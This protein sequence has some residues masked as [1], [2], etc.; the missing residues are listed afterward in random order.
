MRALAKGAAGCPG[1]EAGP[2]VPGWPKYR[3]AGRTGAS[4]KDPH[5]AAAQAKLWWRRHSAC[6]WLPPEASI[7]LPAGGFYR[8]RRLTSLAAAEAG[9]AHYARPGWSAGKLARP[10]ALQ[11]KSLRGP[12]VSLAE[13][14]A[15]SFGHHI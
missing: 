8:R 10:A 15:Q 1:A 12:E 13:G 7:S 5:P 4:V 14:V 9:R 11:T 3:A 2:R 6:F